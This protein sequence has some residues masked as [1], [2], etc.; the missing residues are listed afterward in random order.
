MKH[1]TYKKILKILGRIESNIAD[2]EVYLKTN[3][4]D[5]NVH[6]N[7]ITDTKI[8]DVKKLTLK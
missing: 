1:M 6:N 2:M 5:N 4:Y 7:I 8:S 3:I